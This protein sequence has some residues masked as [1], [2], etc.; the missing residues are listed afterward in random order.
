MRLKRL[1]WALAMVLALS[2]AGGAA[3]GQQNQHIVSL[4]ELDKDSASPAETRQANE[5]AIR[6]VLSSEAG[7]KV[8]QSAKIDY[9]KV[10]QAVGQLSD[11]DVAKLAERSRGVQQDFAAGSLTDRDL[12]VILIIA[13]LVIVLIA[14]LR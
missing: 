4:D 9:T 11:E 1:V 3:W 8:L 2:V 10:D 14:A 12:L 5:A 13:L 7:Q 6:Q